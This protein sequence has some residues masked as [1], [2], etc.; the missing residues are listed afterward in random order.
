MDKSD[1]Q[2]YVRF[3][4][5]TVNHIQEAPFEMEFTFTPRQTIFVGGSGSGKSTLFQVLRN[6]GG[7]DKQTLTAD[8]LINKL[9]VRP[10]IGG[11]RS[12]L[13]KYKTLIFVDGEAVP[14]PLN[15]LLPD[16]LSESQIAA[17]YEDS[18]K[19]FKVLTGVEAPSVEQLKA[20]DS[21]EL[22]VG[23]SHCLQYAFVFSA[24][25][26]VNIDIPIVFHRPFANIDLQKSHNLYHFIF[27][28]E[29]QKIYILGNN[30][31]E[32]VCKD[33]NIDYRL[34]W[35]EISTAR[36]PSPKV[37]EIIKERDRLMKELLMAI[38]ENLP[39]LKQILELYRSEYG[40]EHDVYRFYH[41]SYKVYRVQ[42]STS[43]MVAA[44]QKLLPGR[45]LTEWFRQIVAEGTGKTFKN[46][47][48]HNW[49]AVTR[50]ILEAY[51]H[52]SYF[53]AMAVKYGE[54]LECPRTKLP[55]G[56]AGLLSL[57]DLR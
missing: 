32:S 43:H 37:A 27:L 40:Y 56:W 8:S 22:A 26:A 21:L 29:C 30:E 53:I 6:L 20:F 2:N 34:D 12:L 41:Q 49:L 44:L 54:Q 48:N 47:D 10:L 46:E 1:N 38:K 50:P 33:T 28:Q 19:T 35:Q 16:D 11:D 5:I 52:A 4:K 45:E 39:E 24:R 31:H 9:P 13:K 17:I 3:E 57:Y 42:D 18:R 14:A 23:N 15:R 25:K 36:K 7:A 51:F 55:F